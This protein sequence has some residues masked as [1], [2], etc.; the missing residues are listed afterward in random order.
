MSTSNKK[1]LFDR[2][3]PWLLP[4]LLISVWQFAAHVGWLSSRVL[5]EPLNVFKSG[6]EL[7]KSGELIHHVLVS[8]RRAFIG[9]AIGGGAGLFCSGLSPAH[10]VVPK[11]CSTRRGK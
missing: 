3:L 9:L 7:L 4:V 1:T 2:A 5:P 6:W 8:T 10:S 11:C